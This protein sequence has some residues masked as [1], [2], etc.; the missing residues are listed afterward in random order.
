MKKRLILF[1]LLCLALCLLACGCSPGGRPWCSLNR[2]C[3]IDGYDVYACMTGI[4]TVE[5]YTAPDGT[6]YLPEDGGE[7]WMV[8]GKVHIDP[9]HIEKAY[10]NHASFHNDIPLFCDPIIETGE[11]GESDVTLLFC[12]KGSDY[13]SGHKS[14]ISGWLLMHLWTENDLGDRSEDIF[15]MDDMGLPAETPYQPIV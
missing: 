6:E 13:K 8:K 2:I 5:G 4:Y 11:G 15:V 3:Y 10:L 1:I 14:G 9:W 7:L 12:V